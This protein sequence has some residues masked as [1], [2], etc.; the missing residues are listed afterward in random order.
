MD[1][2]ILFSAITRRG[3]G[4]VYPNYLIKFGSQLRDAPTVVSTIFQDLIIFQR[5]RKQRNNSR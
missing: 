4:K 3:E 5:L 1:V 2:Q